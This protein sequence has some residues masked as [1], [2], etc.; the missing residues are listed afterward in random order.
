MSD[1][2]IPG[3]GPSETSINLPPSIAAD[4]ARALGFVIDPAIADLLERVG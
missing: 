3:G 1:D 4:L 2:D